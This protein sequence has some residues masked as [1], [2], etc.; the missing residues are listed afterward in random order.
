MDASSRAEFGDQGSGISDG[1]PRGLIPD[2][3]PFANRRHWRRPPGPSSR[4]DSLGAGGCVAC[5]SRRQ[6]SGPCRRDC[7]V[8]G[9]QGIDRQRGALGTV[10]AVTVAVPTELHRD[11]AMPFL[12][13][14]ISVLVEKPMARSLAEADEMIAAAKSSGATLAVGHTERYNP[15]VAARAAARDL[16]ALHRGASARRVSRTQPRHRRRLRPDDSRP[17]HHRVDGPFRGDIGRGRRRAG[18]DAQIRYCQR[19]SAV[20][21]R[22]HRQRHRQPHQP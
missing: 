3:D 13:R 16:A 11:I 8:D 12:E 22:L 10:D 1:V 14:G 17:R 6:A 7:R 21:L 5:G 20:C 2:P 18:P 4:E 15:A 19:P 9:D